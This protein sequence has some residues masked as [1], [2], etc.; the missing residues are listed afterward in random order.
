VGAGRGDAF[1]LHRR[2]DPEL[3]RA[4]NDAETDSS[5]GKWRALLARIGA[6]HVIVDP[7]KEPLLARTLAGMDDA[8]LDRQGALEAWGAARHDARICAPALR[9]RRDQSRR[10]VQMAGSPA[11]AANRFPAND[12]DAK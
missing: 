6:S 4:R 5:G 1:S 8:V 9:N 10:L 12:G 7:G 2:Y 3:W 11:S